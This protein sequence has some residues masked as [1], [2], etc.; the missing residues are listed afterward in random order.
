[1]GKDTNT[2][3]KTIRTL[4]SDN[5]INKSHGLSKF[6]LVERFISDNFLLRFNEIT[7]VAEW[8]NLKS[9]ESFQELNEF[10][11]YRRIKKSGLS[12][13]QTDLNALLKSDYLPKYD[14]F[15]YYFE[16]LPKWTT[17]DTDYISLLTSYLKTTDQKRFKFQFKKMFIR[18][19][20]CALDPN[21]FNKHIFVFVQP[22][23]HTGKSS[24]I[25]WL[26]PP[27][28]KNYYTESFEFNDKD[29]SIALTENF[30]INIDELATLYKTE[31]N[32]LKAILQKTDDKNR[33][34]YGSRQKRRIR[35]ASFLGS[36]NNL[37]FLS[38][39]TGNVR[40]ICFELLPIS[41]AI[42][43]NYNN[44]IDIDLIWSQAYSLYKSGF[45]FQLTREEVEENDK[46]NQKHFIPNEE[47]DFI[48]SH[49]ISGSKDEYDYFLTAGDIAQLLKRSTDLRTSATKV[50][51]QLS[52]LGFKRESL[53]IPEM[54]N[55]K[56]GYFI[57]VN[58]SSF[59]KTT[60][61]SYNIGETLQGLH[62]K[63]KKAPF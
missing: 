18:I 39:H 7:E 60:L 3:L 30:I 9:K 37:E 36:T 61:D 10:E 12:I 51:C 31:I 41:N 23:Q 16:S 28:L 48:I 5:Q 53:W 40:W 59:I 32:K 11:L 58:E 55:S 15:K 24:F 43:F 63:S 47:S 46:A 45:K 49:F 2:T 35:R 8:K 54:D 56:Y 20:A 38:D 22:K 34:A 62:G 50:G 4:K 6:D 57:K 29:S 21:I 25:R 26:C 42:N 52:R 33:R 14:P 1:M 44:D 19:V 13:S 27:K 17:D